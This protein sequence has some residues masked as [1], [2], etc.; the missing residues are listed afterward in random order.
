M[1]PRRTKRVSELIKR[2]TADLIQK[3]IKGKNFGL[4]TVTDVEVTNDLSIAKVFISVYGEHRDN[5]PTFDK[6]KKRRR[7][8]RR[9]LAGKIRLRHFPEIEFIW[10]SSFE[11]GDRISRLLDEISN[12]SE[13]N[14]HS[15]E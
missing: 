15:Q 5:S 1:K 7:F 6:L 8:V 11:R 13:N 14:Q 10:D 3:R 4:T 12:D 9:N 2:E